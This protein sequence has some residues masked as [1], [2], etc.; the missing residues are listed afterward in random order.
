MCPSRGSLAP[1]VSD[2]SVIGELVGVQMDMLSTMV[3][4]SH[5]IFVAVSIFGVEWGNRGL[6]LFRRIIP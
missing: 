6:A 2:N 1:G 5:K 4:V 3:L